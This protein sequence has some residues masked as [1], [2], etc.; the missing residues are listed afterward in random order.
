MS[1]C[2]SAAIACDVC[3]VWCD[4]SQSMQ[5]ITRSLKPKQTSGVGQGLSVPI[6]YEERA[7][8][9]KARQ[10]MQVARHHEWML[11]LLTLELEESEQVFLVDEEESKKLKSANAVSGL[12][13]FVGNA[14]KNG[15]S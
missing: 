10:D 4:S 6:L 8:P 2:A 5:W 7:L 14:S 3:V 13:S 15:L 11:S 9:G 12:F 1:G